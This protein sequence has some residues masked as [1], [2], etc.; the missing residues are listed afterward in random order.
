MRVIIAGSRNITNYQI[1]CEA[2]AEFGYP[3]TTVISGTAK[4]VDRL[5]EQWAKEHNVPVFQFPANWEEHGRA[6]G[7]I[8]NAEMAN[9]ADALIA[10]WDGE[11]R[12]TK[13]MI[14]TARKKNL[15]VFV[16]KI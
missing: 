8:R 9:N 13:H 15:I 7:P 4:G 5:G 6:A 1:V 11:S 10:I 14:D 12:G 2:I 16:K 3:I